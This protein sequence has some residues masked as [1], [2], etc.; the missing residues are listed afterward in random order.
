MKQ[1]DAIMFRILRDIIFKYLAVG[2]WA[3]LY[4]RATI[5]SRDLDE[6]HVDIIS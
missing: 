3:E 1:N 5:T 4:F 2:L 6:I